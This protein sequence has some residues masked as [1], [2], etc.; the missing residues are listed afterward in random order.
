MHLQK[1][2]RLMIS[3]N[4]KHCSLKRTQLATVFVGQP[5]CQRYTF[6]TA[7][8]VSGISTQVAVLLVSHTITSIIVVSHVS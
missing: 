2:D 7:A 1:P 4:E 8:N 6:K 5:A 3:T